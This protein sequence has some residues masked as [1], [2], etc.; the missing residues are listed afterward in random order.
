MCDPGDKNVH[1]LAVKC[2]V[3]ILRLYKAS[4]CLSESQSLKVSV[5]VVSRKRLGFINRLLFV[6]DV[7]SARFQ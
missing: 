6:N 7:P 1:E 3:N 5:S 4:V 2:H